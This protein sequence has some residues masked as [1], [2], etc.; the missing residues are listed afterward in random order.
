MEILQ[1]VHYFYTTNGQ[2]VGPVDGNEMV[3]LAHQGYL[4]ETDQVW[5]EGM[6]EW[7]PV[8]AFSQ[9][10]AGIHA[11]TDAAY[12]NPV[13]DDGSVVVKEPALARTGVIMVPL[14]KKVPKRYRKRVSFAAWLWTALLS[15]L[16]YA[17]AMDQP[18]LGIPTDEAL[19][20]SFLELIRPKLGI[21]SEG[22]LT[23][24]ALDRSFLLLRIG[25]YGAL[26][27]LVFHAILSWIYI[28]RAWSHIQE[29]GTAR[30]TPGKAVGF[31]FIPFFNI[32]WYFVC[33]FGWAEDYN[34][35]IREMGADHIKP[36]S[37]GFIL[38]HCILNLLSFPILY[39]FVFFMVC[40]CTNDIADL[41]APPYARRGRRNQPDLA[42][43]GIGGGR[44]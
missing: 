14:E 25:S 28:N 43:D 36:V 26:F 1:G 7:L 42:G 11:A 13:M 23:A 3:R 15:G 22:T 4:S 30:T 41:P 35:Y 39:P 38:A 9:L 44:R 16:L 6:A 10:A 40:R 29:L 33:F 20:R 12:N 34:Q 19:D 18:I 32:Y 5:T 21:I 27:L 37:S 8:T 2:Q 17:V 31:L 24:E